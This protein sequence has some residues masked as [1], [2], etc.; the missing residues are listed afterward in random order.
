MVLEQFRILRWSQTPSGYPGARR[1]RRSC[2]CAGEMNLA[3]AGCLQMMSI[4]SS[5][6]Q[7]PCLPQEGLLAIVVVPRGQT[8][9]PTGCAREGRG[10]M[11]A[12]RSSR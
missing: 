9:T 8:E 12:R 6:F 2:T 7:R 5:P 4:M 11:R 1:P 3:V 10:G